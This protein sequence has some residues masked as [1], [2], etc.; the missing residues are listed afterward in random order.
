MSAPEVLL[1]AH[2]I[3]VQFGGL[4]AVNAVDFTVPVG[5]IVSL[6]GPNGAGKTTFFN[7]LTGLYTPT[8]GSVVFDGRSIVGTPPHKI[9]AMGLARTFQNIRL[10]GTMTASENVMV[11]MHAHL[12]GGLLQTILGTPRQR[13]EEREAKE[14]ASEL[15]SYVGIEGM[16]EEFANNL[17]YGDQRRLEVEIGRASCRERVSLVV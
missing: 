2:A 9:A 7:C 4:T 6:I 14:T 1:D 17:P 13:R 10:F 8:S 15:L 12:H 11:A 16:D 5:G 3:T